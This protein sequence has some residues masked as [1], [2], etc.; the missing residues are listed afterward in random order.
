VPGA[1]VDS[2]ND[3]GEGNAVIETGAVIG[4]LR[5]Y[6]DKDED[7]EGSKYDVSVRATKDPSID[8]VAKSQLED[9]DEGAQQT[10]NGNIEETMHAAVQTANDNRQGVEVEEGLQCD[11]DV[12]VEIGSRG[13]QRV[14]GIECDGDGVG[15]V[16]RGEAVFEGGRAGHGDASERRRQGA[17]QTQHVLEEAAPVDSSGE[18]EA[19]GATEARVSAPELD[20]QED[21]EEG[22]G[23]EVCGVSKVRVEGGG[24]QRVL[25][26]GQPGRLP[27][28]N[29]D[30]ALAQG[31]APWRQAA[32]ICSA[33][34]AHQRARGVK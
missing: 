31:I 1:H 17:G 21:H 33:R 26:Q 16:R 3:A 25:H 27:A 32:G 23:A 11:I 6:T 5:V 29:G 13:A 12:G 24:A 14:D 2:H 34:C 30:E 10:P 15:R 22:V 18:H 20:G 28:H 19:G 7:N 8:R 4:R 9:G